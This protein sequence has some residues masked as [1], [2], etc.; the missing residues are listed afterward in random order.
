MAADAATMRSL[1]MWRS[2]S[3][4]SARTGVQDERRDQDDARG[5][6]DRLGE[7]RDDQRQAGRQA[8]PAPGRPASLRAPRLLGQHARGQDQ[9]EQRDRQID[10][11]DRA[12][13]ARRRAARRPAPGRA[14]AR[15][16]SGCRRAPSPAP[17]GPARPRGPGSSCPTGI[18]SPPPSPGGPERDQR[19]GR[20]RQTAQQ[21]TGAERRDRGHEHPPR[22]EPIHRPPGERGS[23]PPASAG[24]PS[25]PTGSSPASRR[26]PTASRSMATFTIVESRIVIAAP[27]TTTAAAASTGRPRSRIPP[28][29]LARVARPAP[30][31]EVE[32]GA[33]FST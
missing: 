12:P 27:Q 17:S 19:R 7:S 20:P 32:S 28:P 16:A 31:P 14:R 13:R 11:E 33:C 4:S 30:R 24:T 23:P 22:A 26:K 3:G 21:R 10:E 9:R 1:K 6:Q 15:A 29:I 5:R 25:R 8:A 2:I 18:T